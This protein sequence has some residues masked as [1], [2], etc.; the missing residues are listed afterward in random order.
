MD[1]NLS[2]LGKEILTFVDN[3]ILLG[4]G[5]KTGLEEIQQVIQSF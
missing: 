3:I 4:Q 1:G 2:Q 5:N